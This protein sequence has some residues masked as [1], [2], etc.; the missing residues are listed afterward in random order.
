MVSVGSRGG[1]MSVP[2][3]FREGAFQIVS[4]GF[5]DVPGGGF[6]CFQVRS[7]GV[8][9]GFSG[10]RGSSRKLIEHSVFQLNTSKSRGI[11][12]I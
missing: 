10:F 5:R 12:K 1:S 2:G 7:R 11:S 4:G 9:R 3:Y 6:K 8:P